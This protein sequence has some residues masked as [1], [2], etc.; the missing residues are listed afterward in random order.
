MNLNRLA[1]I[2]EA[3]WKLV[4]EKHGLTDADLMSRVAELDL[5]DG[6]ADGKKEAAGPRNCPQCHRPNGRDQIFCLYCGRLLWT[7]PF[8]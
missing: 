2:V 7:E 6:V 5:S 8:D 1:L 4:R 3:M